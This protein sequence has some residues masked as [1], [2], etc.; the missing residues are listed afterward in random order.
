[1]VVVVVV[2]VVDKISVGSYGGVGIGDNNR[3]CKW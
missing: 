2:V 3:G 1:M